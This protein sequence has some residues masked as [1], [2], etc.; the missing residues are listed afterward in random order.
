MTTPVTPE[1]RK[2]VY[3]ADCAEHGHLFDL[4]D[5]FFGGTAGRSM[6]GNP[7]PKKLP[8]MHCRRCGRIWAILEADGSSYDEAES[9]L[10]GIVKTPD[11]AKPKPRP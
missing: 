4:T 8:S 1:M 5:L 11:H 7:D 10:V 3:E 2:A 9:K 6:F